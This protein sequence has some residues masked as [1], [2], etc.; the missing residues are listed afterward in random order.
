MNLKTL[1][2]R[3]RQTNRKRRRKS[4][5][6]QLAHQELELRLAPGSVLMA[7]LGLG[8]ATSCCLLPDC[9]D[10]PPLARFPEGGDGLAMYKSHRPRALPARGPP[11]LARSHTLSNTLESLPG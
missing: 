8:G 7:P 4:R 6:R 11:R 3:N 1:S 5:T 9:R 10:G 2:T